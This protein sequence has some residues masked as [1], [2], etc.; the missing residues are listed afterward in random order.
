MTLDE[1]VALW[2]SVRYAGRREEALKRS[3]A[4]ANQL[5]D[6]IGDQAGR[7]DLF[8]DRTGDVVTGWLLDFTSELVMAGRVDDAIEHCKRFAPFGNAEA[9]LGDE[10]EILSE[11]GR[12]EEAVA[13]AVALLDRFPDHAWSHIV[14]ADVFRRIGDEARAETSYLRALELEAT[15]E[16][17]V[18]GVLE[19]LVPWFEQQGRADEARFIA[20]QARARLK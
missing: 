16:H 15:E 2:E 11:A 5:R 8:D 4:F 13:A 1:L 3:T 6:W 12:H 14:A 9:F 19:R 17:T 7:F 18:E 20:A 10:A